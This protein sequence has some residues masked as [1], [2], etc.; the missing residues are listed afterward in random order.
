MSIAP[1]P[2][3]VV[4]L[5]RHAAPTRHIGDPAFTLTVGEHHVVLGIE[6]LVHL[7]NALTLTKDGAAAQVTYR[8]RNGLLLVAHIGAYDSADTTPA[9]HPVASEPYRPRVGPVNPNRVCLAVSGPHDTYVASL[10]RQ[11]AQCLINAAAHG[12]SDA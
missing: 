12:L 9:A 1:K 7:S 6:P 10:T 11:Q 2:A 3:R 4:D 5:R 8:D